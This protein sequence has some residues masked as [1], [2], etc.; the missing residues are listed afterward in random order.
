M[1][2]KVLFWEAV[3]VLSLS[4]LCLIL[5][6]SYGGRYSPDLAVQGQEKTA[7]RFDDRPTLTK[8]CGSLDPEQRRKWIHQAM[9]DWLK[10]NARVQ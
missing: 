8:S 10:E 1:K 3:F 2:K 9:T 5:W 7:F 6:K 4:T